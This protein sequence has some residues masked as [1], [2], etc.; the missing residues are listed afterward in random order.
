MAGNKRSKSKQTGKRDG[1]ET[2]A[3][4]LYGYPQCPYCQIVLRKLHDLGLDIELRDTRIDP[5]YRQAL[6][7]VRGRATVPVLRIEDEA[8]Q[9]EWLPESADIVEYLNRRFAR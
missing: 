4:S 1:S 8:G 5:A 7:D 2:G 9:V 6:I 3:L